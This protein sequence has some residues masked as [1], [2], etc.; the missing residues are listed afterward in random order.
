[1]CRRHSKQQSV[2]GGY[3]T[4]WHRTSL[5]SFPSRSLVTNLC[6]AQLFKISHLDKPETASLLNSARHVYIS[7]YFLSHGVESA[8]RIANIVE[9]RQ[10]FLVL[11]LAAPFITQ[12]FKDQLDQILPY[13]DFVIGNESEALA[14]AAAR[15]NPV[16]IWVLCRSALLLAEYS[17]SSEGR[18]CN[19]CRRDRFLAKTK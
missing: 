5:P 19:N 4:F 18:S 15:Q 16:S 9:E 11:N 13:A 10:Q 14:W 3:L 1:M 12:I 2:S 8:L 17:A 6:A 7:G